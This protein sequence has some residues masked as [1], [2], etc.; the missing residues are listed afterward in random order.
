VG[1]IVRCLGDRIEIIKKSVA[2]LV[3][4]KTKLGQVVDAVKNVNMATI[5]IN[6]RVEN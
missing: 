6:G 2:G 5:R 4:V 3:M 1:E